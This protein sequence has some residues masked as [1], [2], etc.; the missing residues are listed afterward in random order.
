MVKIH[1]ANFEKA[2][3]LGDSAFV[4]VFVYNFMATRFSIY[5]LKLYG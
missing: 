5:V 1:E 3:M 2:I 4:T